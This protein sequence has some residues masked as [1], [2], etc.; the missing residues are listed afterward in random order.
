VFGG[1]DGPHTTRAPRRAAGTG[2]QQ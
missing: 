2:K 1:G